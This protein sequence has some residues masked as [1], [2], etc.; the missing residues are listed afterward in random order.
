MVQNVGRKVT[1]ILLLLL[2][3]IIGLAV[4]YIKDG[5]P[6]KLGLDLRGGSR[7]VYTVDLERMQKEQDSANPN[8][9]QDRLDTS[10]SIIQKRIDPQGVL[11]ITLQR[12]GT[13]RILVELPGMSPAEARS[14]EK[15]ITELGKLEFRIVAYNSQGGGGQINGT[16]VDLQKEKEKVEAWWKKQL[17][18]AKADAEKTVDEQ[19]IR[20]FNLLSGTKEGPSKG[21]FWAPLDNPPDPPTVNG[22]VSFFQRFHKPHKQQWMERIETDDHASGYPRGTVIHHN[23]R[24]QNGDYYNARMTVGGQ[25]PIPLELARAPKAKPTVYGNWID[26]VLLRDEQSLQPDKN[27][28]FRGEDLSSTWATSDQEGFPA[29]GFEF[30]A[31]RADDFSEF[32][33]K[34]TNQAMAI[35]LNDFVTSAPN[36]NGRLPGSGIIQGGFT[37]NEVR[38]GIRI[39]QSGS[40]Q[41][42]LELHSKDTLG[43][44]LG[45]EAI[46][47][48]AY[49]AIAGILVVFLFILYYYRRSGGVAALSLLLNMLLLLGALA[50]FRVNLNL[51]GI[52]GLILTLGMAVDANILIF[53]RIREERAKKRTLLQSARNGFDKAFSTIF[54]ANVTTLITTLILYW[55]G[56]G[57]IKGFA[58]V[59]AL[60]ILTSMFAAL[61]ISRV[62]YHFLLQNKSFQE[63]NMRSWVP[64]THL[65]FSK[66][67]GIASLTSLILILAGLLIFFKKGNEIIGIDFVGGGT[68][69]IGFEQ[70]QE[71]PALREKLTQEFPAASVMSIGG[72]KKSFA[73]KVKLDPEEV[74]ERQREMASRP[75]IVVTDFGLTDGGEE[76]SGGGI[77]RYRFDVAQAILQFE[78]PVTS[79]D[80]A[81]MARRLFL[82]GIVSLP[83]PLPEFMGEVGRSA[84]ERNAALR[85]GREFFRDNFQSR[86][87]NVLEKYSPLNESE[88]RT[89]TEPNLQVD[90]Q[91]R[92]ARRVHLRGFVVSDRLEELGL[93][94][95]I[96]HALSPRF[97][98]GVRGVEQRIRQ[99][100]ASEASFRLSPDFVEL[101]RG[102]RGL[103]GSP[104]PQIEPPRVSFDITL[105]REVTPKDIQDLVE[106]AGIS[107]ATIYVGSEK[108]ERHMTASAFTVKHGHSRWIT[109][110]ETLRAELDRIA[111][112][113][114]SYTPD[115]RFTVTK[116]ENIAFEN[117]GR[118]IEMV[119]NLRSE[120]G[121][122][123][124]ENV[125]LAIG[126]RPS[127][128]DAVEGSERKAWNVV[129]VSQWLSTPTEVREAFAGEIARRRTTANEILLTEGIVVNLLET[130][131]ATA[132]A[133][134]PAEVVQRFLRETTPPLLIDPA[135][136]VEAIEGSGQTR[137]HAKQIDPSRTMS[138]LEIESAMTTLIA[139]LK[140]QD[141]PALASAS[142]FQDASEI[143][144]QASIELRDSAVLAI[145]VSLFAITIYIR[146]RFHEYRYAIGA[147]LALFHDVLI[148]LGIVSLFASAGLVD[149][150]L[151]LTMVAA[152]L[153]II[154][155]SLNDTIVIF[156][157]IRENLPRSDGDLEG[158]I[159][160]SINESLSR[161]LLT[162]LTTLFTITV[163]FVV[164]FGQR[165]AIEGFSFAIMIGIITGTYSTMFIA[166][167]VVLWIERRSQRRGGTPA[168]APRPSAPSETVPTT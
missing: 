141:K 61:V 3:A 44:T 146:A 89:V 128:L 13:N 135:L 63:I 111:A 119:I 144:P 155:Y 97:P 132:N 154:G 75:G 55:L 74:P 14:I 37:S 23:L 166:T 39:L 133:S 118:K 130:P 82:Q 4:P 160:R 26:V 136:T 71:L 86:T 16:D 92:T 100:M 27:W 17:A 102:L 94:N 139:Q 50:V 54:D 159:N 53:E 9:V 152:F 48:G 64:S 29:I 126:I 105:S 59:L 21:F 120:V 7:L 2:G 98:L 45:K 8:A 52:A 60:G 41:V 122:T 40:L 19:T 147:V 62:L 114:E 127:S 153:T 93:P 79:A 165:N 28:F 32:T 25:D 1:L 101:D 87:E 108:L 24:N 123:K 72:T 124:L 84:T 121:K 49:S 30:R 143:S 12:Q 80:L 161:T 131:D 115:Q 109:D 6:L 117:L 148:T 103:D 51:P 137:F 67:M 31:A 33:D 134:S 69:R 104:D 58:V 96:H 164:N 116:L 138:R 168:V 167:P 57:P 151:D 91:D 56:T 70:D 78:H 150:E 88:R 10:I 34:F 140:E 83:Q 90:P 129:G 68:F 43:P 157:R 38:D 77:D 47:R 110:K 149:A 156:D 99:L 95:L 18:E 35:V 158:V 65:Q 11:N 76:Q 46:Q 125:L 106:W 42:P 20:R 107:D 22:H 36:I 113:F 73:V 15:L 5:T 163:L 112:R 162:S 66:Y 85:K 145:L 81:E 142:P